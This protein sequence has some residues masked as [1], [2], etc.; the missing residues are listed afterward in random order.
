LIG[1]FTGS[2]AISEIAKQPVKSRKNA[3]QPVKSRK[4]AKL[5]AKSR[6]SAKLPAKSRK[7]NLP[8]KDHFF[9]HIESPKSDW[10]KMVPEKGIYT[11]ALKQGK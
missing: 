11:R 3:K 6:K 10:R 1:R 5:P 7:C 9:R 2:V 8:V 4:N